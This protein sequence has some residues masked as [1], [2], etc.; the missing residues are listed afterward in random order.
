MQ[1]ANLLGWSGIYVPTGTPAP[2]VA[3]LAEVTR[4]AL[5]DPDV[6]RL[7]DSTGTILLD[8]TDGRALASMLDEELLRMEPLIAS[9]GIGRG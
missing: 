4:A 7:F 2:A 8:S 9:L 3:R 6:V 1:G 5:R